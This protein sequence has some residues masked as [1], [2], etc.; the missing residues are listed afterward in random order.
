MGSPLKQLTS[1]IADLQDEALRAFPLQAQRARFVAAAGTTRSRSIRGPGRL[2]FLLALPAAAAALLLFLGWPRASLRFDVGGLTGRAGEWIEAPAGGSTPVAFSEG[3]RLVF[4][5][6]ARGRVVDATPDGA[7]I[8]LERGRLAAEIVHRDGG[9][10]WGVAAGPFTVEIVGTRFEVDWD[11]KAQRFEL[12][13]RDGSLTVAGPTIQGDRRLKAGE[14]LEIVLAAAA[15]PAES[16]ALGSTPPEEPESPAVVQRS[17]P[18][19]PRSGVG[20]ERDAEPAW[21][22]FAAQGRYDEAWASIVPLGFDAVARPASAADLAALADVARFSGHLPEASAAFLSLRTRF[23]GDPQARDVA[24][25]LGRLAAD[26]RGAHAEAA[27]WFSIYLQ[28]LPEGTFAG[29][30][31]GR[32]IECH[33]KR[34]ARDA[35]RAAAT[36]YLAKYPEGPYAATARRALDGS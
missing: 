16:A 1:D 25:L 15:R 5:P 6:R 8:V 12:V 3:T 31:A 23:P 19:R 28:E 33:Q 14:R 13:L 17:A 11:P 32:L 26:Q 10:R 22:L 21:R 20:P 9:T 27:D 34:G 24:F 30:A 29:E 35:A 7:R 2:I 4:S 18:R 36:R